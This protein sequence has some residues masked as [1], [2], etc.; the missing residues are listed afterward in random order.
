MS[1]PLDEDAPQ[2][3]IMDDKNKIGITRLGNNVRVAGTAH[4]TDFNKDL[5]GK[6]LHSL[7]KGLNKLFPHASNESS[8]VNFWTTGKT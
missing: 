3:T 8:D 5:R 2:S 1:A 4:L 7:K 6:S